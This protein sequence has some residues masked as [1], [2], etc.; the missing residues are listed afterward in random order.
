MGNYHMQVPP[1]VHHMNARARMVGVVKSLSYT[2]LSILTLVGL[3]AAGE[4]LQGIVV[5]SIIAHVIGA[6]YWFVTELLY[7]H[8]NRFSGGAQIV[9]EKE[10]DSLSMVSATGAFSVLMVVYS[11]NVDNSEPYSQWNYFVLAVCMISLCSSFISCL[12]K[13]VIFC[14]AWTTRAWA[15]AESIL[16]IITYISLFAALI[17]TILLAVYSILKSK[18]SSN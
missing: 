18:G 7:E 14:Y 5:F 10:L 4:V 6:T 15:K 3:M 12:S 2:L 13:M 8:D 9:S 17:S 1:A 11:K 16:N